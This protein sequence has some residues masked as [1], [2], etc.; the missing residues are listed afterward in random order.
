M[1]RRRITVLD[2]LALG[3]ATIG[4][5]NWGL[6]GAANLNLVRR[7]FGRGSFLERA[8]YV[9]V[10]LA[11]LNLAFLTARLASSF[12]GAEMGGVEQPSIPSS[13]GS[14][15]GLSQAPQAAPGQPI[16]PQSGMR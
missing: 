14:Q 1:N 15:Q 10:G 7:I 16:Y 4:A 13:V 3:V 5:I 9:V 8:V 6:S 11:G 12:R 2:L